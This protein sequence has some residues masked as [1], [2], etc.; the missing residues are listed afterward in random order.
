MKAVKSLYHWIGSLF[1]S[2]EPLLVE[3]KIGP[4]KILSALHT[5]PKDY[6]DPEIMAIAAA[7]NE[8]NVGTLLNHIQDFRDVGQIKLDTTNAYPP[9][10]LGTVCLVELSRIVSDNNNDAKIPE[11]IS[12]N[13][14]QKLKGLLKDDKDESHTYWTLVFLSILCGTPFD[15]GGGGDTIFF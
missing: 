7:V 4:D 2:F 5:L 14:L 11:I 3:P 15:F 1:P 12:L 8:V 6:L 10:F 9:R 13:G